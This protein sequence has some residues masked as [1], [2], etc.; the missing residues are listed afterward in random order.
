MEPKLLL[1]FQFG[2]IIWKFDIDNLY[3]DLLKL[4]T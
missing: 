3:I 1:N 4:S 2:K